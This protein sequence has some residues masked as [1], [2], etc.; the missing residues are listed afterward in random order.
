MEFVTPALNW[1]Y[2]A[3]QLADC[4]EN[5]RECVCLQGIAFMC[6]FVGNRNLNSYIYLFLRISGYVY[7]SETKLLF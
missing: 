1:V 4:Q 2:S 5:M 7:F 6:G 3:L